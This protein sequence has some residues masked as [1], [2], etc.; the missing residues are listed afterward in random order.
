MALY[1]PTPRA[2]HCAVQAG[3]NSILWGGLTQD[4]PESGRK[5]LVY[6]IEMFDNFDE[7]WAKKTATENPPPGLYFCACTVV[8]ETLYHFG[9]RYGSFYY[10]AL[11]SLNRVTLQWEELCQKNPGDQ[12]MPKSACGIAA[13]H[14]KAL[15]ITSLAVFAGYGR[16]NNSTKAKEGF[17]RHDKFSDG[18]GWTNEFHLFNLEN[19]R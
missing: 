9:G 7:T 15:G 11:H 19:G 13:Y 10:N 2:W 5:T 3:K 6:D 16:L 8:S 18:R 12:P 17:F 14:N 4:F 1:Q